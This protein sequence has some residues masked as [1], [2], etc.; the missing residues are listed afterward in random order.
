MNKKEIINELENKFVSAI[1][2]MDYACFELKN[3]NLT[4]TFAQVSMS[5]CEILALI[6]HCRVDEMNEK[7]FK[8]YNLIKEI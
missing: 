2:S 7:L 5:I 1:K 4:Q 6:N 3:D 8:K